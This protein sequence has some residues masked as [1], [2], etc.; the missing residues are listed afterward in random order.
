MA[1]DNN[2][3]TLVQAY[4]SSVHEMTVRR[5]NTIL[6]AVEIVDARVEFPDIDDE[7][8]ACACFKVQQTD[9]VF[10]QV[11]FNEVELKAALQLIPKPDY[12]NI[13]VDDGLK[14]VQQVLR[15]AYEVIANPDFQQYGFV[16]QTP[17]SIYQPYLREHEV[18]REP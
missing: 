18:H 15:A 5:L 14:S 7:V 8:D 6:A 11:G 2:S 16:V 10:T 12:S 13:D 17:A 9:G 4:T 3:N 1:L